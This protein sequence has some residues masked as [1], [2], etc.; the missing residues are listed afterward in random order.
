MVIASIHW[1]SNWGYNTPSDQRKFA[2]KLIDDASVDVIHG[3]T[4]HHVKGMEVYKGKLIIYG[5]IYRSL[6]YLHQEQIKP[7]YQHVCTQFF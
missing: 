7:I 1:G 6:N 5:N 3:H 4:S 2:H